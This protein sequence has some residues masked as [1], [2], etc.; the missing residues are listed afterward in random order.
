MKKAL[1]IFLVLGIIGGGIWFFYPKDCGS[2]AV[3]PGVTKMTCR[4]YGIKVDRVRLEQALTGRTIE[5]S[6]GY[7]CFGFPGEFS[8]IPPWQPK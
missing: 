2:W 4:C 5:G 1:L 8:E 7:V 6:G 3:V